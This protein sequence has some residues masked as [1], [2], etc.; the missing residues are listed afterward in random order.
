VNVTA[1]MLERKH[2]DL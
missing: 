1:T 2:M